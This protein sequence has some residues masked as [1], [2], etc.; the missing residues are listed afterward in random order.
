MAKPAKINPNIISPGIRLYVEDPKQTIRRQIRRSF[1]IISLVLLL[2]AG[3]VFLAIQEIGKSAKN[4]A[5]KQNELQTILSKNASTVLDQNLKN[6]WEEIAPYESKIKQALPDATNLLTYQGALE[7]VAQTVGVQISVSF[8]PTQTK[9][10]TKTTSIDHTVELKGNLGNFISFLE[11][12][13][14]LPYFVQ[15]QNFNLTSP[16]G[17]DK[18]SSATLSLK[19]YTE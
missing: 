11:K 8:T 12:L 17:L 7:Q 6:T 1:W 10:A 2:T 16:Q 19:V 13:E 4:L 3:L 5:Q 15:V 9:T 18:D 14:N